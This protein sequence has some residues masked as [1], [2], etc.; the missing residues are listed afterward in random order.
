MQP[1]QQSLPQKPDRN[2]LDQQAHQRTL[3]EKRLKQTAIQMGWFLL[4]GVVCAAG[5]VALLLTS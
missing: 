3:R 4:T 1:T 2:E 5:I